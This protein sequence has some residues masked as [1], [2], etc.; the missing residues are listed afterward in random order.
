MSLCW[1]FPDWAQL[2]GWWVEGEAADLPGLGGV[3]VRA[4]MPSDPFS[5]SMDST[6][7]YSSC[8]SHGLDDG[9]EKIINHKFMS[10]S[11]IGG[12]TAA[13]G[14]DCISPLRF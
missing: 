14:L 6:R 4:L 7:F 1:W 12:D 13:A 5:I 3:C 11:V 2:G 8:C 10:S 9:S